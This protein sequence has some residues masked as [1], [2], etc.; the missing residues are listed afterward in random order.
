MHCGTDELT[1]LEFVETFQEVECDG[2]SFINADKLRHMKTNLGEKLTDEEVDEMIREAD[3]DDDG[4]IGMNSL[5]FSVHTLYKFSA[6]CMIKKKNA[7]GTSAQIPGAG[8]TWTRLRLED[9]YLP[10]DMDL[11]G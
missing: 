4:R 9:V 6:P 10:A 5:L 1:T 8:L 2:K 7:F 3:V 11:E